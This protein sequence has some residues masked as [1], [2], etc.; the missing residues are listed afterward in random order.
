VNCSPPTASQTRG[1]PTSL[2]LIHTL[3][4]EEPHQEQAEQRM[5]H[6]NAS[7]AF[8]RELVR[9]IPARDFN[10]GFRRI[11]MHL[12]PGDHGE[13]SPHALLAVSFSNSPRLA[14]RFDLS[15][16]ISVVSGRLCGHVPT[17]HSCSSSVCQHGS[18]GP[19]PG[20][21]HPPQ[22]PPGYPSSHRKHSAGPDQPRFRRPRMRAACVPILLVGVFLCVPASVCL[23]LS[24]LPLFRGLTSLASGQVRV[25]Q[26]GRLGQRSH[27]PPH[28]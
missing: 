7:F 9:I 23:M 16:Y 5:S 13:G 24:P 3:R 4:L 25:F 12:A 19:A 26:C 10:N 22:D 18:R 20:H 14:R 2:V 17:E 27:R 21:L 11:Q 28:D 8:S 1:T 6:Q 15:R